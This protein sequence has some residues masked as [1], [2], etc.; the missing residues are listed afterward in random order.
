LTE[1]TSET[2]RSP[3]SA[4]G[5]VAQPAT[6]ADNNVKAIQEVRM[7]ICSGGHDTC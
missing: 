1:I 6:T 2:N 5:V 3:V 7:V 4:G